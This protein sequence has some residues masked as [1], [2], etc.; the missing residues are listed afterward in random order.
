M[1]L[2]IDGNIQKTN[3][4]VRQDRRL[5]IRMMAYAKNIDRETIRKILHEYLQMTKVRAKIP[6]TRAKTEQ[7]RHL[8]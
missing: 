8:L 7:E 1:T 6:H 2:R 4:I 3:E 5:S